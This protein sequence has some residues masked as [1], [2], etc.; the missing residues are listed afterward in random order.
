[1]AGGLRWLARLLAGFDREQLDEDTAACWCPHSPFEGRSVMRER[2][3]LGLGEVSLAAKHFV[4]YVDVYRR[5]LPNAL[6]LEDHVV[7]DTASFHGKLRNVTAAL[8][9]GQD[10]LFLRRL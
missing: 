9:V 10:M 6:F 3:S 4:G 7:F 5:G 1:M 2:S 8:P